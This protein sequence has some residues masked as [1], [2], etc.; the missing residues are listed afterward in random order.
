M[1]EVIGVRSEALPGGGVGAGDEGKERGSATASATAGVVVT[2]GNS[3]DPAVTAGR[4][5]RAV[6]IPC[7][8]RVNSKLALFK[9]NSAISLW[10]RAATKSL[11]SLAVKST[12]LPFLQNA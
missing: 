7:F 9:V 1:G 11:S 4:G 5:E 10:L 3:A 2:G 8:R 6:A 12:G